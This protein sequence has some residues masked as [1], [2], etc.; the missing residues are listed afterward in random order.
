L[1]ARYYITIL[2]KEIIADINAD[3][4]SHI[5]DGGHDSSA[6]N[7]DINDENQLSGSSANAIKMQYMNLI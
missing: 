4:L 7:I 2:C 6:S 1:L 3:A 5:S